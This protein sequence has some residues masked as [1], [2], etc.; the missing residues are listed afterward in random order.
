MKSSV[1]G[2]SCCL[3]LWSLGVSL[4]QV[5]QP[6]DLVYSSND[7]HVTQ[8]YTYDQP[9]HTTP[10]LPPFKGSDSAPSPLTTTAPAPGALNPPPI[11]TG[12][13][14][15]TTINNGA[16]VPITFPSG[17]PAPSPFPLPAP[18]PGHNGHHNKK[19]YGTTPKPPHKD[20]PTTKCTDKIAVPSHAFLT[21]I[22]IDK[23]TKAIMKNVL[24]K[25]TIVGPVNM[26]IPVPVCECETTVV[27]VTTSFS[28]VE[29]TNRITGCSPV[30]TE[31]TITT[32]NTSTNQISIIDCTSTSTTVTL[33]RLTS[34]NVEIWENKMVFTN[35]KVTKTEMI[36]RSET[37]TLTV[38]TATCAPDHHDSPPKHRYEPPQPYHG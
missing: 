13:Q 25:S 15:P 10:S 12:S 11:P 5:V 33:P 3:L 26:T 23:V 37:S 30:A 22:K 18:A 31:A 1:C 4:A 29:I 21:S 7:N 38:C 34:D 24:V 36:P 6:A 8:G 17:A 16:P 28:A 20:C 32:V 35:T 27:P 14:T 2:V 9:Q 19:P